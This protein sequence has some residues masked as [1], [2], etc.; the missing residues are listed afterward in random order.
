MQ[1][2]PMNLYPLDFSNPVST[3]PRRIINTYPGQFR[4]PLFS[5]NAQV[6]YKPASQSATGVGTVRNTGRKARRL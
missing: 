5:N 1:F 6:Y 2:L 3:T 4:L